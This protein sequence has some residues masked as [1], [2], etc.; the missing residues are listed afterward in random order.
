MDKIKLKYINICP[1]KKVRIKSER[2]CLDYTFDSLSSQQCISVADTI[3]L[4][5]SVY[6]DKVMIY[7]DDDNGAYYEDELA[8]NERVYLRGWYDADMFEDG[9]PDYPDCPD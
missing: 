4:S 1:P 9:M 8:D 7:L 3:K 6:I 2:L 5:Q